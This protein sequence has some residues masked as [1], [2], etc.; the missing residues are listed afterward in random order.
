LEEVSLLCGRLCYAINSDI[1]TNSSS[2]LHP[3]FDRNYKQLQVLFDEVPVFS[4]FMVTLANNVL[5]DNMLGMA[6]RVVTGAVMSTLDAITDFYVIA[7]YYKSPTLVG[8]ANALLSMVSIS[9]ICQL[10]IVIA[11]Y[12]H[13]SLSVK[14]RELLITLF[15]LRPA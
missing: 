6:M 1:F 11:Q 10:L 14:V 2:P 8:Q 3:F 13:K 5:R 7:T 4:D 9:M 12:K 15:Y